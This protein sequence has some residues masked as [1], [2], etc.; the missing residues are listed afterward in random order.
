MLDFKAE[1]FSP[2]VYLLLFFAGACV[3]SP[4]TPT[5]G[6]IALRPKPPL[7]SRP[8]AKIPPRNL[9]PARPRKSS[10]LC[11]IRSFRWRRRVRLSSAR[12]REAPPSKTARPS[13]ASSHRPPPS[14]LNNGGHQIA[15]G[16]E[17]PS[18]RPRG[19]LPPPPSPRSRSHRSANE[20]DRRCVSFRRAHHPPSSAC[21]PRA[22]PPRSPRA[23]RPNRARWTIS[24]VIQMGDSA[25]RVH[26]RHPRAQAHPLAQ[27]IPRHAPLYSEG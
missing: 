19:P 2:F 22:R 18:R 15:P 16:A 6:Q 26:P 9:H 1:A 27:V 3:T 8:R 13:G 17:A 12:V 7:L 5:R 24:R 4:Y 25:R 10:F 20:G 14:L 23:G 11:S 21:P